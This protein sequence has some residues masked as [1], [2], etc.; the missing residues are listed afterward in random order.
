M[1]PHESETRKPMSVMVS[2]L[3]HRHGAT[4]VERHGATVVAHYGSAVS[5]AAVCRSAVGLAER[6][7]RATLAIRGSGEDIDRALG[8][9]ATLQDTAWWARVSRDRAIVR[10]EGNDH[11]ACLSAVERGGASVTD[12]GPETA[13]VTLIGPLAEDVFAAAGMNE[14]EDVA[15]VLRDRDACIEL[16]VARRQGPAMWSRLLDAGERFGIACV[17]LDAI[18]HLAVSRDLDARRRA[19]PGTQPAAADV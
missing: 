8:E 1:P 6:S 14:D 9:L 18:E 16:L 3:L 17:G 5:E 19:V 12:I 15:V 13:A 11:A 4:L 10:C 7:D 2:M